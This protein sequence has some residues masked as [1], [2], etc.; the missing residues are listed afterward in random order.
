MITEDYEAVKIDDGDL[1][2]VKMAK[3]MSRIQSYTAVIMVTPVSEK[4]AKQLLGD[5]KY[6]EIGWLALGRFLKGQDLAETLDYVGFSLAE[7][8]GGVE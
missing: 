2:E 8:N 7:M 3:I 4:M 1:L 5:D 6:A